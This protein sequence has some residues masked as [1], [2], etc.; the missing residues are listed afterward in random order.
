MIKAVF[1]DWFNT[2]AHYEP[3]RY[4]L[5][6]Q[7]CRELGIEV[8]PETM[9][10]SILIADKYF[11]EEN[12]KS[13]VEKRSPEEKAEVYNHYQDVMFAEAGVKVAKELMLKIRN[14]VQELFKGATWTL[15]DDVLSTLKAL[16]ARQLILG[17]LTNATRDMISTHR[18]L[19]LEPYLNFTVTSEEAGGD[20]PQ[21]PIF[22]MALER[23]G[24][25]ASE[26]VHVGDQY[27]IDIVGARGAGINPILLD[28]YDLYPEVTDCPRIRTLPQIVD[29]I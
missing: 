10:R 14:R 27:K 12:I 25:N 2:L 13:P 29:H 17:L 20:K 28:R 15:F 8:S 9:I 21:P 7:A 1:F 19:G 11:F 26:A 4:L 16:K 23:A 24:V 6:S 5:H 18:K 3:P 22:L